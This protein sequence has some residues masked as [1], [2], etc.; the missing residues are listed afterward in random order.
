MEIMCDYFDN[1]YVVL[2]N[3]GDEEPKNA[4]EIVHFIRNLVKAGNKVLIAVD[5]VHDKKMAI[6]FYIIS[7]LEGFINKENI[8]FLL[9]ARLP[10]YSWLLE[11]KLSEIDA[12]TYRDAIESFDENSDLKYVDTFFQRRGM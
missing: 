2:Y 3:F 12:Q 11:K 7:I 9:T 10:E 4:M 6:I 1:G 5:N 8:I